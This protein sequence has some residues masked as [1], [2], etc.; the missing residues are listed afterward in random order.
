MNSCRKCPPGCYTLQNPASVNTTITNDGSASVLGGSAVVGPFSLLVL[1]VSG[2]GESSL[3]REVFALAAVALV[4]LI[5][6]G[7]HLVF[8]DYLQSVR[9][10]RDVRSGSLTPK[11]WSHKLARSPYRWLSSLPNSNEEV[12]LGM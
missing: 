10:I 7:S 4:T 1:W 3:H 9:L 5:L 2:L 6:G 8:S 11:F 12:V